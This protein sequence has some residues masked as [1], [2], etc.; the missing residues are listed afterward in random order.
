MVLVSFDKAHDDDADL[1]AKCKVQH[2]GYKKKVETQKRAELKVAIRRKVIR[3]TITKC[4][5]KRDTSHLWG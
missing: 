3:D 4:T 1:L 2:K 5:C